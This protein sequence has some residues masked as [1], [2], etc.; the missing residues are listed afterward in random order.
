MRISVTSKYIYIYMCVCVGV[1]VWAPKI[2]IG[3]FY[4]K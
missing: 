2:L 1:C 3:I 4:R